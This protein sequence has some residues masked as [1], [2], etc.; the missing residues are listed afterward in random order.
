MMARKTER[1][2]LINVA[3]VDIGETDDNSGDA[4]R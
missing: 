3:G 4:D 2:R 1:K